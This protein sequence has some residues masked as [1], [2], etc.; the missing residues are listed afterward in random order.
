[1]L[2][3]PYDS[4]FSTAYA[5]MPKENSFIHEELPLFCYLLF[6]IKQID[7]TQ[8]IWGKR[9]TKD[10]IVDE[11]HVRKYEFYE[12]NIFYLYIKQKDKFF[13]HQQEFT[14]TFLGYQKIPLTYKTMSNMTEEEI[15]IIYTDFD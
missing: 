10:G 15:G 11:G 9:Y 14:E 1:M 12:D 6:K 7:F 13:N 8:A 5:G 3:Y 4:I 2:K